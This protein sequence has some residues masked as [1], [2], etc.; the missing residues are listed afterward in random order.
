[1]CVRRRLIHLFWVH[2]LLVPSAVAECRSSGRSYRVFSSAVDGIV[3]GRVASIEKKWLIESNRRFRSLEQFPEPFFYYSTS[4][5]KVVQC[6]VF[7]AIVRNLAMAGGTGQPQK[8]RY[9]RNYFNKIQITAARARGFH[10][11][12]KNVP[13]LITLALAIGTWVRRSFVT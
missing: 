2:P 1:M 11:P 6:A 10:R 9:M 3:R 12:G 5:D 8:G 7:A 13:V 4:R